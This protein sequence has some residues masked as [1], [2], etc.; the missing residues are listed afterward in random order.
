[1]VSWFNK[2]LLQDIRHKSGIDKLNSREKWVL[3][4]G[5]GFVLCFLVVQL[6]IVPV[7]DA[8]SNL[9]K[10]IARK[11]QELIEIKKLTAGISDVEKQRGHY[12]GQNQSTWGW[13][14]SLHIS[15]STG[16]PG[17]GKKADKVHEALDC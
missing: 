6:V 9:Q 3:F 1:M 2:N 13:V 11:N 7:I 16:E 17:E 12:P 4:G 14:H 5:I 15:R 10:S 8:R